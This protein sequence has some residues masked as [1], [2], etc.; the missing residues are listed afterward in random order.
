MESGVSAQFGFL[1]R[2][3]QQLVMIFGLIALLGAVGTM[4]FAYVG[5]PIS[6]PAW[7]AGFAAVLAMAGWLLSR[8]SADLDGSFPVTFTD[9]IMGRSVA[10]DPRLLLSPK[11]LRLLREAVDTM[12]E[13][14]PL[15]MPDGMVR[16]DGTP[17]VSRIDEATAAVNGL[18]QETQQRIYRA[19][20]SLSGAGRGPASAQ[21]ALVGAPRNVVPGANVPSKGP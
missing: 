16:A 17:D 3:S 4:G 2:G 14:R 8:E 20:A 19:A 11:N 7:I 10:A 15:P 13:R 6:V 12:L 18:N 1:P 21:P 5:K 9:T